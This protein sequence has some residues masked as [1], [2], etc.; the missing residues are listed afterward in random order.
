MSL[1]AQN[2][3]DRASMIIQDLTNVRWP[4]TELTNWL[5]DGRRELAVMRPDIYATATT[6]TLAAGSKQSLPSGSLRLLDVPRN[7]GGPAVTITQ[8]GFLDQQN[9]SW[10]TG[11]GTSTIKHFM[12]DERYP[13]QFWV[14]PP[15]TA[16]AQVE[17]IYEQA[18]TDYIASSTLTSFEELYGGALVDY[19]CYRAFSKD[20][21]YAGNAERAI[22]HYNQFSNS[23]KTG[24][25]VSVATSPNVQNVG[26]TKQVP[27]G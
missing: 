6:L 22:A 16:S 19:V 24:G 1:T 14:Y 21:E 20:S 12:L 7:V 10:T 5:N 2:I 4:L 11:A 17:V 3:M 23:L 26:G 15:A 9:P 18:P 27:Q 13:T 25:A 8:R